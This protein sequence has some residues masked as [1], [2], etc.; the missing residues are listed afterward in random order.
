MRISVK[1]PAKINL[2]L[3]ILGKREDGYHDVE[4]VMTSIDL[5]DRLDMTVREDGRIVLDCPVSYVPLDER[6]H[7]Y[8]AA[9]LLQERYH[10]KQG[11]DI[12]IHKRIPVAAGLAGGSTD[13][14]AA[15]RGL[16]SLWNLN[17][18]IKEMA[19]IGAEIGSDV[20]FCI[21]GGTAVARGRGE[22]I[23][24]II[25]P[26]S[27]WVVLAK[28][29]IG[30]STS[31]VYQKLDLAQLRKYRMETG[32]EYGGTEKMKKALQDHNFMGICKSLHNDLESVTFQLYPE[33]ER[34]KQQMIRFGGDGVLMS[35]SG[36]TVFSLVR[37]QSRAQRMYNGLKGFCKEVY[38]VRM[39]GENPRGLA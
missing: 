37:K 2:T 39:L 38:L 8:K 16:N 34:L 6:N 14:A 28:P 36:P 32:N 25:S 30:V 10:V 17:L 18:T 3:D 21:Y 31:E 35:G 23:E 33:V 29:P 19:E 7:V 1:A 13:A 24:P 11:V 26:P 9:Q 20:P 27:C 22:Q 5:A 12:Y 4:M 15:I